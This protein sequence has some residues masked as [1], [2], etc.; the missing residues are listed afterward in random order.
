[1]NKLRKKIII[2]VTL[3][4][5]SIL[6]ISSFYAVYYGK[7]MLSSD[8]VVYKSVEI[9]NNSLTLRGVIIDSHSVFADYE[10]KIEGDAVFIN[11]YQFNF[12]TQ[13]HQSSKI[14]ITINDDFSDIKKIYQIN[15][16]SGDKDIIGHK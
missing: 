3:A 15:S 6:L 12:K 8:T 14:D 4:A 13:D 1:M 2:I 9:T 7:S 10:Y 5:L 11:L 16:K